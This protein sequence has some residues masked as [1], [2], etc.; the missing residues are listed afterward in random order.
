MQRITLLVV[1]L[2]LALG[3]GGG[4]S[5][6]SDPDTAGGEESAAPA[7]TVTGE[8]ARQMVADGAFLLDV[9]PPPRNEGS[10]IEG[11]TNIP[12]PELEGRMS[13]VPSDQPVVVYCFGG[14]GSPPAGALLQ[15]AGYDVHVMGA[16]SNWDEAEAAVSD[17]ETS[18]ASDPEVSE[19]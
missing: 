14:R 1:S 10:H 18:E 13:E 4:A 15:A 7:P 19:P 12:F 3:C 9:T 6:S 2:C 5:E 8:Q 17:P 11:A 16:R